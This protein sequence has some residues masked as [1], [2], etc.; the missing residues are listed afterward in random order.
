MGCGCRLWPRSQWQVAI[1]CQHAALAATY[2]DEAAVRA[3]FDKR[4]KE[5]LAE[6]VQ[7]GG[8][9]IAAPPP[10]PKPRSK[11]LL[12]R[13]RLKPVTKAALEAAIY[14]LERTADRPRKV[15]ADFD[16]SVRGLTTNQRFV[17][18]LFLDLDADPTFTAR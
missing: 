14:I 5:L 2:G 9:P 17:E 18:K 13:G 3:A 11:S 1:G 6:R 4:V 8:P 16:A 7:V 10:P 12:V 15:A